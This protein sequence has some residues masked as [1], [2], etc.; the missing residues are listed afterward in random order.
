MD[1]PSDGRGVGGVGA[2]AVSAALVLHIET[3]EKIRRLS[4]PRYGK[5]TVASLHGPLCQIHELCRALNATVDVLF[6]RKPDDEEEDRPPGGRE[7][8]RRGE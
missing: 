1:A 6:E 2:A 8:D 4:M 5:L 3:I 7:L